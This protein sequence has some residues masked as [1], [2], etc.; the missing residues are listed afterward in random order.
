[1]LVYPDTCFNLFYLFSK[2]IDE[3]PK[4]D[5]NTDLKIFFGTQTGTAKVK[6]LSIFDNFF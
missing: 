5:T 3:K 1:M 2:L 6:T 4:D